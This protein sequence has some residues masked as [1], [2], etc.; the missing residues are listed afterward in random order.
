M[1]NTWNA[2][3]CFITFVW[4]RAAS[5]TYCGLRNGYGYRD[6]VQDIQGIEHLDPKMALGKDP[7]DDFRSGEQRRGPAADSVRLRPGHVKLPGEDGYNYDPY[8]ADDALWL[9]P[10]VWKYVCETG[11]TSFLDETLP[12]ADKGRGHGLRTPETRNPVQPDAQRRT[13]HAR[14]PQRGLER[15]PAPRRKG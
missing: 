11:D 7:P 15:L 9:F 14:R 1:V 4:S 3:Q 2:Y 10:T 8:R 6:T 12:F 13:R 5:F